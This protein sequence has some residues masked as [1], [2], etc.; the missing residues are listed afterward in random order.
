MANPTTNYGFVLPTPTD[1]V[2]DLPADFEVA[3]QG[4]DTQ[5]KTNADA[6]I[7]KT[8]VDAK[9][10]LI[11]ATAADTVSRLA[12]GTNDQ[13]LTADSTAATGMKW[14]SPASG[15]MT[16]ISNT[17]ASALS[18]LSLSSIP[19]T[20]KDLL[21][22]WDGI[23]A[24]TGGTTFNLRLNN[25][26]GTNYATVAMTDFA[27]TINR[28]SD[29]TQ[30]SAINNTYA[31]FGDSVTSANLNGRAKGFIKIEDYAS[32]S[33]FKN[34]TGEWTFNNSSFGQVTTF[35]YNTIYTSLSAITSLDIVRTGGSGTFSNATSTSIRLYGIS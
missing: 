1:L 34:V 18:S 21:I 7:A 26:S 33:L 24:S 12:V 6:A 2:T 5:M 8:I 9:G 19:G 13:V 27:G 25:D 3:L 20:Y 23:F 15:G 22:T 14:A 17:V 11:A 10:D 31:P 35:Y 30:T 29:L 4:V 32:T 28:L 16:L